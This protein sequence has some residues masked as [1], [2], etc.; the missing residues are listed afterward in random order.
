MKLLDK[1]DKRRPLW[2]ASL[3]FLL[4][5]G[6]AKAQNITSGEYFFDTDPGVGN[7]QVLNTG[8]A[9][10]SISAGATI[11]TSGLGTG[12]HML[13]VRTLSDLGTWS[14]QAAR[15]LCIKT[16]ITNAEY[17]FD[18]DPG[19]G[20]GT[21]LSLSSTFDSVSFGGS[22]PTT[23]LEPGFHML[24]VRSRNG[25]GAWSLQAARRFYIKEQVAGA[26]YFFDTDPGNGNGTPIAVS[27]FF[28]SSSFTTP[29]STVGLAP[30]NHMLYVR[31]VSNTGKW[32]LIAGRKITI[33]NTIVKAEYFFDTDPGIGNGYV[34]NVN[35]PKDSLKLAPAVSVP[36]LTA[37]THYVYFRTKDAT[38]KWSLTGMDTIDVI[39]CAVPPKRPEPITMIGN[40]KI[41]P[42]ETRVFE[43][44]SVF[45]ATGFFW[46][47]PP[48]VDIISGQGTNTLT[49]AYNNAFVASDTIRVAA[50][51]SCGSSQNR[52]RTMNHGTAPKTPGNID[53]DIYGVCSRTGVPY[54]VTN[55]AGVDYTWSFDS[56]SATVVTGQGSNAITADFDPAF[57][58]AT[59]SVTAGNG[60]GVSLPKRLKIRAVPSAP[61]PISGAASACKFTQENYSISAIPYADTYTWIAPSGSTISDG[62]VTSTTNSLTTVSNTVTVTFGKSVGIIKVRANN[63]CGLSATTA[64]QVTSSCKDGAITEALTENEELDVY[65]NPARDLL[66]VRFNAPENGAYTMQ[67]VDATGKLVFQTAGNCEEGVNETAVDVSQY[68][69]GV[70]H[71]L[72][73]LP[74]GQYNRNIVIK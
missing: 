5:A 30:G 14:L 50:V 58:Y 73:Y 24:Y 13:Y 46:T 60:C 56:L 9:A 49:V 74:S 16:P 61:G 52:I 63:A 48:G 31:S 69:S 18:T 19:V 64:L 41:C 8:T 47:V 15:R 40:S 17:F 2:L 44:D 3:A 62:S 72:L 7:G 45:N 38:G 32:S 25:D 20:N 23:G 68:A 42:G 26:E 27:A 57:T 22:I 67:L 1:L 37:G 66:H 28:D 35:N 43:V 34:Y 4:C 70:Y 55:V 59:L 39:P 54:T 10:D 51:N 6:T 29:V 65:P 12:Y 21:A 36:A 53:G 71:L 33:K 11:S